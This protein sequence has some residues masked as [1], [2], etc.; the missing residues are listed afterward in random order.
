MAKRTVDQ[1]AADTPVLHG[2][3]DGPRG[4]QDEHR[5]GGGDRSHPHTDHKALGRRADATEYVGPDLLP[6]ARR[7]LADQQRELAATQRVAALADEPTD[8]IPVPEGGFVDVPESPMDAAAM[9]APASPDPAP[10]GGYFNG[11]NAPDPVMERDLQDM[12]AAR[13]RDRKLALGGNQQALDRLTGTDE[14]AREEQ[15]A[16]V[17]DQRRAA[18]AAS[19]TEG[20]RQDM[21]RIGASHHDIKRPAPVRQTATDLPGHSI[22]DI[23]A[24]DA[25]D[26]VLFDDTEAQL[27]LERIWLRT[28]ARTILRI[29]A[30]RHR[31]GKLADAEQL[32]ALR[33]QVEHLLTIRGLV[34]G[35]G[36]G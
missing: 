7:E 26:S 8:T 14:S 19:V 16:D 33:V 35:G 32:M 9:Q 3:Y 5:H 24:D 30:E 17:A 15:R 23:T 13:E 6:Q 10:V 21:E 34:G 29:G 4:H 22:G 31:Y 28:A 1:S 18:I 36:S 25:M 2:H 20:D 11:D 27:K 12:E